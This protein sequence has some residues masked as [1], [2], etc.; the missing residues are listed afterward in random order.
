MAEA[1][2]IAG[3]II[4]SVA[5]L[6]PW[7]IWYIMGNKGNA[8]LVSAMIVASY[9]LV[10]LYILSAFDA[11][12]IIRTD[13]IEV[14]FPR[15][16]LY[17]FAFIMLVWVVAKYLF[18]ELHDIYGAIAWIFWDIGTLLAGT[19]AAD[20]T[21]RWLFF[22]LNIVAKLV[23]IYII[24]GRALRIHSWRVITVKVLATAAIIMYLVWW[25]LTYH[26]GTISYVGGEWGYLVLDII[27]FIIFPI[28][29]IYWYCNECDYKIV[30]KEDQC[31]SRNPAGYMGG[32][33]Y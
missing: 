7:A 24:W 22:G 32:T 2:A 29:V 8:P 25:I 3:A 26:L 18:H 17:I 11:G 9:A 23:V 5:F 31:G 16:I 15:F 27:T 4:F 6:L 28:L 21:A 13:G 12:R 33:D 1:F 14:F 19:F 30:V 10:V 20:N